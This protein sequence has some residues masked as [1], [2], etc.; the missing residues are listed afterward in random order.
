MGQHALAAATEA[1]EQDRY[2][3][4][5]AH[6]ND[7]LGADDEGYAVRLLLAETMEKL[8]L[9]EEAAV[10]FEQ[11]AERG[12]PERDKL[13]LRACALYARAGSDERAQLIG[14]TLRSE[15]PGDSALACILARSLLRTG[16][17]EL[18]KS[19]VDVLSESDDIE[20]LQLAGELL[21]AEE[22]NPATLKVFRKLA[23][24]FHDDP[25]TQLKYLSVARDFCDYEAIERVEGW[26][27]RALAA[28]NLSVLQGDAGY[29]NLLHCGVERLNRLATNGAPA[30]PLSS[31]NAGRLR[32]A[33]AHDWQDKI[34]VGYLSSDLWD[35]H[36]TMRLFRSVLEMHDRERFDVTLYCYT[37]QRF[38]GFDAGGRRQWGNIVEIG[39][40]NDAEAAECIRAH[41]TDILI[42]LKGHTGGSR[43]GILNQMV[44]PVQVAWLGFPGSTVNVA[45]DYVIGDTVVLPNSSRPHYHEKFCR[46]PES[47]QPN[48]PVHRAMPAPVSRSDLGLPE[49]GFVFAAFNTARKISLEALECWAAIL[50]EASSSV[51][52]V[53][54][55]GALARGNFT[56]AMEKRGVGPERMIFAPKTSYE[57]HIARLPAADVALDTFPYNGHTTTSDQLW[58]GLPVVT[59]KGSNFASRVS[60]SLLSALGIEGLVAADKDGF[61]DLAVA[62]ARDPGRVADLKAAIAANRYT[63]PLFDAERFCRHLE[64]AFSTMAERARAKQPPEHFDVPAMSRR[65]TSFRQ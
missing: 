45:C 51:L 47:Y 9:A 18:A 46:L 24:H 15:L 32:L 20:H 42:D 30:A 33:R 41:G 59:V 39:D 1:Y 50:R 63:A 16:D 11:A 8:G 40:M 54:V 27:A 28:G 56:A 22:R 7:L 17:G 14:L 61:V 64:A 23:A 26:L 10:A 25:F 36:A 21:A 57:A 55:D 58:A 49:D 5:L 37:P 19:F 53:M 4:V 13:L 31:A 35:D 2:I 48:D 60:E 3:D 38:V 29:A 12:A 34:R 43:C 65:T 62:L 6:L 52:W 44:S